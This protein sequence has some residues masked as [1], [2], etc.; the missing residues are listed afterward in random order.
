MRTLL[1]FS[2][3]FI[4]LGFLA[5]ATRPFDLTPDAAVLRKDAGADNQQAPAGSRLPR[6]L[7]VT[8]EDENGVAVVRVPIQW[9]IE[10]GD[11]AVLSDE[12]T[13]TDGNGQA[14]VELTLGP[15]VGQ[16]SVRAAVDTDPAISTSF[17][18]QADPAPTLDSVAPASFSGGDTVVINGTDLDLAEQF[19]FADVAGG[20]IASSVTP[21]T[22][23][24][25]VP[26]C[27]PDGATEIRAGFNGATSSPVTGT[28]VPTGAPIALAPGEYVSVRPQDVAGCASL[29]AAGA[30]GAEYLL[31]PQSAT[32]MAGDSTSY[33]IRSGGPIT[34]TDVGS[35]RGALP[36][37]V[38]FHDFLRQFELTSP[39]ATVPPRDEFAALAA[40]VEVGDRR[41]FAVCNTVT[42]SVAE[43]FT[44]VDAEVKYVGQ[45]AAIYQDRD[46]PTGGFT[47]ADFAA[48][49]SVFDQTLYDVDTRA[50]GAESDVD[51]NGLVI[52]LL[53]PVVN[54]LTP[55]SQCEESFVSGFF[56]SIDVNPLFAGD[57]RS[58][59]GEVF[60]SFVPDPSGSVTCDHSTDRVRTTVPVTFVH[61]FQHMINY[62]QH[63]LLRGGSGEELWLNE[64]MSHLAEELAAFRFRDMGDDATFS[65]YAIGNLANAFAYLKDPQSIFVLSAMGTG[66]LEERGSAWL[67][68]RWLVDRYGEGI[69]RR[70]AESDATG[71]ENVEAATGTPI[72][73]DLADWFLS[74]WVSDLPNFMPPAELQYS[75][76]SFRTTFGSLN[77][78]A[79][80]VFD[81]PFPIVPDVFTSIAA[82]DR[83]GYLRAGS[84]N[85][86]IFSQGAG[87]QG[88]SLLFTDGAGVALSGVAVPR[89]NIIRIR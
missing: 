12:V 63:V 8:A 27:L 40:G 14:L 50:F 62:Y 87:A 24:V 22:V 6:P 65:R 61:E 44:T 36:F 86:F 80:E 13:V 59:Q 43:D 2:F 51:N 20:L 77:Q 66:S 71:S 68:L 53:T 11:G 57:S 56:F 75:T 34:A 9:S 10:S 16:Y 88:M 23:S 83:S 28:F 21:S 55:V 82:F 17:T 46:A 76:W 29:P 73:R 5:C 35:A 45:H 48:L 1:A 19:F 38:K 58:N 84:G 18:A 15:G 47:D 67:F 37:A 69:T 49:G 54:G 42:C 72:G 7:R 89:L 26:M 41:N 33:R 39:A 25:V 74:N 79:P 81:R 78:Q 4:A 32:G 70:L 31:A 3:T 30:G 85:Y 64:A 60:Y 52:I